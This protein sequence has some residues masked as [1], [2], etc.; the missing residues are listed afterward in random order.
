MA[1]PYDDFTRGY[2]FEE[3][4]GGA[5]AAEFNS[6]PGG[7]MPNFNSLPSITGK[8]DNARGP[9]KSTGHTTPAYYTRSTLSDSG[10]DIRGDVSMSATCWVKVPD[11]SDGA[12]IVLSIHDPSTENGQ[13]FQVYAYHST[14][15]QGGPGFIM[16]D[17][18]TIFTG[19]V[20]IPASS[21][22]AP[23]NNTWYFIGVSRDKDSNLINLF[24]GRAAGESY[25]SSQADVN[26]GFG[27]SGVGL[28][29]GEGV[30]IG[31]YDG[32]A[33]D[34]LSNVDQ[35]LFWNGRALTETDF[36]NIWQNGTGIA[37]ADLAV[38]P[39]A[40]GA[41]VNGGIHHYRARAGSRRR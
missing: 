23:I 12:P 21:N 18:V 9:L 41:G 14:T 13:A 24:Y 19:S 34:S 15:G 1:F 39:G 10:W 20:L 22:P 40:A 27:Y 36:E 5:V 11:N 16:W 2:E 28:G 38:D 6:A 4:S 31:R 17:G 33:Q 25:F 8:F 29:A 30:H 35:L 26:A 7:D 3:V 37:T 32:L